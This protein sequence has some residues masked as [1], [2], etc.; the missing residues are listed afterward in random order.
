MLNGALRPRA[1]ASL[2]ALMVALK[3]W[4]STPAPIYLDIITYRIMPPGV[5]CLVV[6]ACITAQTVQKYLSLARSWLRISGAMKFPSS[7]RALA[8]IKQRNVQLHAPEVFAS[9]DTRTRDQENLWNDVRRSG[10]VIS[11]ISNCSSVRARDCWVPV[12][13]KE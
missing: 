1:R 4:L 9:S 7:R 12:N 10:P 6:S 13:G 8:A 5:M 3:N 11:L 2:Y